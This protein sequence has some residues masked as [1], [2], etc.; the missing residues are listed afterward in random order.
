V[1]QPA[2]GLRV[3]YVALG[4]VVIAFAVAVAVGAAQADAVVVGLVI[5][6]ILVAMGVGILLLAR[7]SVTL[8][9]TGVDVRNLVGLDH[10]D[11]DRIVT[12]TAG[13]AGV[14][15]VVADEDGFLLR[16][17]K[18]AMAVQRPNTARWMKVETRADRL[19]AAI[20]ERARDAGG[21]PDAHESR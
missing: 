7:M 8:T 2:R 10:V 15:L 13:T 3:A 9:D 14:V 11:W 20:N 21:G 1:W 6:P 18:V 19:A 4:V 5:G 12:A 16:R 17:P